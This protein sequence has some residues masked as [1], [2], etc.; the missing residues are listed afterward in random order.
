MNFIFF[1]QTEDYFVF[2]LHVLSSTLC[3][4]SKQVTT[5]YFLEAESAQITAKFSVFL[6][7]KS[8]MHFTDRNLNAAVLRVYIVLSLFREMLRLT[9]FFPSNIKLV[10]NKH[11]SES[12]RNCSKQNEMEYRPAF[13]G[14]YQN[15]TWKDSRKPWR[16]WVAKMIASV[17]IRIRSLTQTKVLI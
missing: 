15:L 14:Q 5:I 12:V 9:N 17:E 8:T 4:C 1:V 6:N 2:L 16:A 10:K 7:Q 11:K 3:G 13:Q